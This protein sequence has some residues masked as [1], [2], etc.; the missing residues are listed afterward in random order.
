VT[1]VLV[2]AA[3]VRVVDWLFTL[4]ALV[5]VGV[6]LVTSIDAWL[7]LR[8][9]ARAG[10]NGALRTTGRISRRGALASMALHLG[11][12][13]LGVAAVMG[14]LPPADRYE[15]AELTGAVYVLVQ[16]C[17]VLAQIRNQ[18]DRSALRR[19]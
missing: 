11:F 2:S 4:L 8:A 15:R 14:P 6:C 10:V 17:V 12:L 9:R 5:G 16:A 19:A 18:V 3:A 13:V 1:A 7:D